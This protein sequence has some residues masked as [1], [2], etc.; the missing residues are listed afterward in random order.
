MQ[1]NIH[2]DLKAQPNVLE[3]ESILRK[4][5]HCGFCTA[6]CPTYQL[7]GDEL[8]GP[9]GR[10][11]LIKNMLEDNAITD[12]SVEHLD[13]CLTCRACETTCPSGVEYGRLLDIGREYAQDLS[14]RPLK[15]RI[16]TG[17]LRFFVPR[18][19]LFHPLLKV[20]QLFRPMLPTFLRRHIPQKSIVRFNQ[21]QTESARVVLLSGCVQSAATPDVV[22]SLQHILAS[23]GIQSSVIN[24]GCCGA[25]DYH[26]SA[27][28]KGLVRMRAVIDLL[29]PQLDEIDSIVSSATGCGVTLKEYPMIFQYEAEYAEKAKAL[30]LKLVDAVELLKPLDLVA[31][32]SNVAVHT[33]CS[34]QH[35]MGLVGEVEQVLSS[36]GFNILTHKDG[37]LCCGSAGTYSIMQP[38]LSLQLRDNKVGALQAN[39]PEVIVTANIGCQLQ[40]TEKA[41][42]PVMHW[43]ELLAGRLV[44]TAN[45]DNVAGA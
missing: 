4:C 11:Y 32:P 29:Y 22:A 35:G 25:L 44:Q 17:L 5:V 21:L 40:L 8:D 1:T 41:D 14:T 15:T 23:S 6:T 37:H 7:L 27:H 36:A 28:E 16:L 12:K 38:A 26:L 42:V 33:P 31:T 9:R 24:E 13:R 3:A 39:Q 43:L 30:A 45:E 34:M 10:I 20:G 19:T 2:P 18:R